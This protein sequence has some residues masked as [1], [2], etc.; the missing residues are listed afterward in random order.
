MSKQVILPMS[1]QGLRLSKPMKLYHATVASSE[2]LN[3]GGLK[4]R[5]ELGGLSM[6]GGGPD[7]SI[8]MTGDRRVAEAIVVALTTTCRIAQGEID[9]NYILT[10][11]ESVQTGLFDKFYRYRNSNSDYP[12]NL[13]VEGHALFNLYRECLY[14]AWAQH[15]AVY[16]PVLIDTDL[17]FFNVP[18]EELLEDICVLECELSTEA[19]IVPAEPRFLELPGE[20]S[21]IE[22][23]IDEFT[24]RRGSVY[25]SWAGSSYNDFKFRDGE[26]YY[27]H[28]SPRGD[29]IAIKVLFEPLLS[30]LSN[31]S[32]L[33]GMNE[34]RVWDAALL[35]NYA[36]A[37]CGTEILESVRSKTGQDVFYPF[38]E[39]SSIL[40]NIV[41]Y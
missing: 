30:V 34:Y 13:S 11:L 9:A 21:R 15:K 4:P 18:C 14:F 35:S 36:E 10:S 28:R 23:P 33:R 6:T 39:Q 26:L 37:E 40:D 8:S 38:F 31:V 41:E 16:D 1:P 22:F 20:L 3:S 5:E 25:G 19:R 32:Y 29:S 27:L 24:I 7:S 17:S 12:L 2:V